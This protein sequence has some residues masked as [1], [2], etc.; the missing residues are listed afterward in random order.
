MELNEYL[1]EVVANLQRAIESGTHRSNEIVG[2]V[3]VC[4][5]SIEVL[6][7]H[8]R[9]VLAALRARAEREFWVLPRHEGLFG[10]HESETLVARIPRPG[11]KRVLD[12]RRCGR[13]LRRSEGKCRPFTKGRYIKAVFF[14]QAF[15]EPAPNS[16]CTET[17]KI[18]SIA[19]I[20]S[21]KN[22]RTLV[23]LYPQYVWLCGGGVALF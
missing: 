2:Y 5:K 9:K 1:Q 12:N 6:R 10:L 14:P 18:F 13:P 23:E 21:D 7:G 22:C 8:R 16:Q 4:N 19:E 11:D 3:S 20:Y 17:W 15:C